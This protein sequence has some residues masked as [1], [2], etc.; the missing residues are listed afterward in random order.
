MPQIPNFPQN[1]T[2]EHHA[3]H[4]PGVHPGLPTRIIPQGQAGSGLEFL[5]F[6]RTFIAKF[7]AWYDA[8]PNADQAAVAPW[9]AIP[10]L[11]KQSALGWNSSRIAEEARINDPSSFA[12][13][14]ALGIFIE[15]GIHGWLHSAAAN[16]F[17]EPILFTLHSNENTHFY[18]LHGLVDAWWE[19][20]R[21][22]IASRGNTLHLAG[23][24]SDGH[25]WHTIRRAD[26]SWFGFGDVEV[27]TG[28][29]GTIV[30]VDLQNIGQ[31]V[32]L[33]AVNS[34]GQLWHTI[35]RADGSWF[36]FGDVKEQAG[37]RGNFIK[38]GIAEVNSELHV[39]GV[40]DD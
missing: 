15:N 17:N 27:E 13:E 31:E 28:D 7:H 3:W 37:D 34:I 16:A 1:L 20:Y 22:T 33:C 21:N 36:P 39:C 2:D 9:N 29:R 6:H 10:S 38:V 11:L 4:Q 5:S 32:H 23:A 18:Q 12:S 8:Q 19:R 25:L 14:D 40:T 35:R 24:T 30:D 26:G